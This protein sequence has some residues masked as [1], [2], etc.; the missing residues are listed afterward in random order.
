MD[1]R[2]ISELAEIVRLQPGRH[3]KPDDG[4]CAMELVA[5]MAGERHTDRP[6]S[7]SPVIAAFTRSF[8]DA[9]GTDQRQRLGALTARMIGTRGTRE[10]ELARSEM[11]WNWMIATALPEWLAAADRADLATVVVMDRAA[12]L[13][14]ATVALDVYGHSTV[15]PVDDHRISAEVSEALAAAGVTGACLAANDAADGVTGFAPGGAGTAPV[16]CSAQQPGWWP[17]ATTV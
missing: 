8:N 2:P 5:W 7:V 16:A 6:Q 9:L 13:D 10:Q 12:A 4:V 1:R 3:R 11:L 15:R 14:R 17:N